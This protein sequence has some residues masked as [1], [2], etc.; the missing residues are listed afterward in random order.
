MPRYALSLIGITAPRIVTIERDDELELGSEVLVDGRRWRVEGF[1]EESGHL[2]CF[3]VVRR[4]AEPAS[5]GRRN[6]ETGL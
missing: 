4:V 3:P 2:I 6:P 1:D 5:A